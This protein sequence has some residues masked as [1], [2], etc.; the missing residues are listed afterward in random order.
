M[1]AYCY[2]FLCSLGLWE[3][4]LSVLWIPLVNNKSVSVSD[5]AVFVQVGK[6]KVNV[7][8]KKAESEK[9]NVA[10]LQTREDNIQMNGDGLSYDL[11]AINT[12]EL[13]TNEYS[14]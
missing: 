9:S 5:F 6:L 14:K 3:S 13:L 12:L 8:R 2:S 7:D 11:L 1:R 4:H 10:C